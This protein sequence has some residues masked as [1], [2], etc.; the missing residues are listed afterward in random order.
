MT[1]MVQ[2]C[3]KCHHDSSHWPKKLQYCILC[4]N[5]VSRSYH[6]HHIS[7]GVRKSQSSSMLLGQIDFLANNVNTVSEKLSKFCARNWSVERKCSSKML[8]NLLYSIHNK[9]G[10]Y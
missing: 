4:S 6:K 8:K 5:T 9:K 10:M 1:R 3:N 2:K 7:Q